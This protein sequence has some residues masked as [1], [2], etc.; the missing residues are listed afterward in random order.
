MTLLPPRLY[1]D[2]HILQTVPPANLNRDDQGNPKEA[3]YGGTRRSRVS[4]QAWKRATRM[5]FTEHMPADDLATRTRRVASALTSVLKVRTGLAEEPASRLA[6]ALLAPLK[7]SAGRKKGDTAYLLFYGRRQLDNVAGLVSDRAAELAAL[8]DK[9]LQAEVEKLAVEEQFSS[10]H[11]LDVALFGRMVADIATLRVDA[12]VQVA[13]ALSTH[14]VSLEFDYFT[15]VDDLAEEE[16]ETGAGM[17]GTIG[18]N[19]ATLYRY[20]TVSLPQLRENLGDDTAAIEGIRK[21]VTSFARSVPSGY[22]NSFAHQTL[23]SLVS[24][25]VRPDQPVNLVTAYEDP[26]APSAGIAAESARRLAAEHRTAVDG[27]GDSPAF[28]AVCHAFRDETAQA[29][30]EAFGPAGTFP[31]LLNGL[32]EHLSSA[33]AEAGR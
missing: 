8:D 1:V 5:H 2:V 10:G 12:A 27:W 14:A 31:E 15:A 9:E 4:S 11:P 22:R 13:H 29:L 25:V 20:A 18:F 23:P 26:V 16:R 30:E 28:T 3:Y 19:S 33:I 7:I 17:I 24:V 32:D 21:F 6:D